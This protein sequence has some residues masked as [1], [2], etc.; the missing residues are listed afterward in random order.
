MCA[1]RRSSGARREH[2]LDDHRE[3]DMRAI[4]DSR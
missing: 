1:V 4:V 2:D 3:G